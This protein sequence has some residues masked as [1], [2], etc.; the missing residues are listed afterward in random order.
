MIRQANVYLN[1]LLLRGIRENFDFTTRVSIGFDSSSGHTNAQR[2]WE[3]D[4]NNSAECNKTLH[5][6]L[7]VTSMNVT[8]LHNPRVP[9]SSWINPTPQIV[10]FIRPLRICLEKE[11]DLASKAGDSRLKKDINQLHSHN[12]ELTN[13]K[14]V[15]VRYT[16]YKTLFDVKDVNCL[17]NNPATSRCPMCLCTISQFNDSINNFSPIEENL[18]YGLSLL[19]AKIN[20]MKHCLNLSYRLSVFQWIKSYEVEG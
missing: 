4:E 17:V 10:R 16:V 19:H 1:L 15:C 3:N 5:Q 18:L 13:G 11:A 7:F 12:F 8:Q 20:S 14:L 6:S 9:T 2:K